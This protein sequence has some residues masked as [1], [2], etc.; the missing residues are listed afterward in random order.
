M[1]KGFRSV[2]LLLLVLALTASL[3]ACGGGK[4]DAQSK[5]DSSSG[6]SGSISA[7][8][9]GG[10]ESG[11][12]SSVPTDGGAITVGIPQDLEDSLDPHLTTAAGTREV[13]FNVFEGLVKPD[14]D[15]NI[16]PAVAER[17][18]ISDDGTQY[19]FTLRDGIR[20]HNGA[21]VTADDVVFSISRCAGLL[22][23]GAYTAA[24]SLA[25]IVSVEKTDEKTVVITISEGNIEFLALLATTYAA[26]IPQDYAQQTTAPVGT[27]P[28][29]FVSRAPQEN[30]VVERFADYWGEKAHLERVTFKIITDSDSLVLSLKSGAIDVCAHLTP[31]QVATIRDEFDI[32]EDTMKLVQA[33]YLNH[34]VAPF[35]DLRVR[36]A[37]C[38][39]V[40]VDEIIG[41]VCDGY[42][43]RV[44][45]SMFPA[46]GKYFDESLSTY[47]EQDTAKAK[48]LLAEAGYPDGF[49]MTITV[50]SDYPQH[51]NA[52]QVIVEQLKAVGITATILPVEWGTWLSDVYGAREYESTLVGFDASTMTA[53]AMLERWTSDHAKNMIN[54]DCAEYDA[55]FEQAAT[56][57]DDAQQTELYRQMERVLTEQAANVYIE[58]LCDLVAVNPALAGFTFYPIYV[59]D[60]STV[61]YR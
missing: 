20:F 18:E 46:F 32:Y 7:P 47:Y 15:G 56:C 8:G 3:C 38:Y 22:D 25:S 54:F 16:I 52:A 57:T 55:L 58:D 1:K 31:D 4:E 44:G 29:R 17:Y 14:S 30:I 21:A 10:A 61:Y 40:N 2:I 60:L 45:S 49:E 9:Q 39:A 37:L 12:A 33:L 19:T 41:F 11:N 36:Q 26:I 43:V 48:A 35:D 28:F 53:R 23:D 6:Q 42:G 24:A 51:M 59:L 13:L 34:A 50:P 5:V 27:G